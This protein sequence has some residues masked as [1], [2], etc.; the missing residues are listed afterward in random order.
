MTD[1][2]PIRDIPKLAYAYR[3]AP[4]V[5]MVNR[6]YYNW[7]VKNYPDWEIKVYG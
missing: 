1:P 6:E 5:V 3:T 2:D 4:K 7:A